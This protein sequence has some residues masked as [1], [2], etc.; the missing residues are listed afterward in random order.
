VS[1]RPASRASMAGTIEDR[2]AIFRPDV[3]PSLRA[4]RELVKDGAFTAETL[5]DAGLF[6]GSPLDKRGSRAQKILA[7]QAFVDIVTL[8][9]A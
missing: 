7:M 6:T 4:L 5:I 9:E 1:K 8:P 2:I 3:R